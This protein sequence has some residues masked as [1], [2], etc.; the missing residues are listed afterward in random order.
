MKNKITESNIDDVTQVT[1]EAL[2][3]KG[4]VLGDDLTC[5]LNEV[6]ESFLLER[7]AIKVA[8]DKEG[9]L[10]DEKPLEC[11]ISFDIKDGE[12]RQG[13]LILDKS[14]DEDRVIKELE[15]G[16]ILTSLGYDEKEKRYIVKNTVESE[17]VAEIKSQ[18]VD[19]S[20]EIF[21]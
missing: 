14:Y 19:G 15:T 21:N 4:I 16:E 10:E 8:E 18:S 3:K 7:C 9:E 11:T 17:I 12:A 6:L 13:I 2:A 5:E 20:Y 1:A